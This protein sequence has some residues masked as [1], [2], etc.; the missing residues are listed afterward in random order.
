MCCF[1]VKPRKSSHVWTYFLQ[2]DFFSLRFT[3]GEALINVNVLAV[4][5][6]CV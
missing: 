4:V 3:L 1:T 6:V 2:L 5:V